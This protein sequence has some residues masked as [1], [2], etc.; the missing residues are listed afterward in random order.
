MSGNYAYLSE[1][2]GYGLR[3]LD[4]SDPTDPAEGYYYDIDF[5]QGICV[6]GDYAY[7]THPDSTTGYLHILDVSDPSAPV[8]KGTLS[9]PGSGGGK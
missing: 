5:A 7:V 4:I 6:S 8:L 9:R 3:V 1:G 2:S